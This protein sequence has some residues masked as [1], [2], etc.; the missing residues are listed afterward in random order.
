MK[1]VIVVTTVI[2]MT[3][4]AYTS[5]DD[6]MRGDGITASGIRVFDGACACG[7]S[8][9]FWTAFAVPELGRVLF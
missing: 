9:P 2:S 8:F 6:G 4:T 1:T 7:P 3:V 5:H